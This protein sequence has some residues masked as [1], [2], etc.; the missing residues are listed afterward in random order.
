MP[1]QPVRDDGER[2]ARRDDAE[3]EHADDGGHARVAQGITRGDAPGT[4]THACVLVVAAQADFEEQE[5]DAQRQQHAR[6]HG[7]EIRGEAGG[8]FRVDHRGEGTK[9]QQ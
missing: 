9:P 8:V 1:G 2:H 3:R 5:R 7:A 6:Q 4:D